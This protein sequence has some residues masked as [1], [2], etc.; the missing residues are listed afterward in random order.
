MNPSLS[1]LLTPGQLSSEESRQL[2]SPVGFS[3]VPLA[4]S[5]LREMANSEELRAALEKALPMLLSALA[6]AASPDGSLVNFERFVQSVP[7]R[8]ELFRYLG[9]NPRAVEILVKLF[10][11]SQFLTEIL[12]RN[13]AYLSELTHHRRLAEFKSRQQIIEEA[14]AAAA[15]PRDVASRLDALRRYQH[16]ELLRIGACDSFGLF[17][18]KSITVQLSLL[19]D[20]MVQTCLQILAKELNVSTDGLAIF[21]FGKLGGEELNYS[22]D[23]DL[24][25][26][27]RDNAASYWTLGQRLIRALT[28]ATGEG[29]MY[30]VDMR[31][32][33]WGS[34]G[35][36]VNTIDAHLAYLRKHGMAWEKQALLKARCIAGD[37]QLG[38]E[39][40][41]RVEP[42]IFGGDPEQYRTTIADMKRKIEAKAGRGGGGATEGA[43][44]DVKSGPGGIRDIE[45][46]VQY[47]Q[48]VHG[49]EQ[50][51]VRSFNTLDALVRLA[52][53]ECL[54]PEEYRRLSNAYVFFRAI[55]HSLQLMHYKQTHRLPD[56]RRELSYLARRLDFGSGDQLL[57]HFE[58][59]S[60]AVRTIFERHL[61]DKEAHRPGRETAD[62]RKAG[63]ALSDHRNQMA[64]S[65]SQ[66]FHEEDIARH[67]TL[68]SRLSPENLIEVEASPL[69]DNTY[70]LTI[71]GYNHLGELSMICG[72]L[73]VHGF[74]IIH[75]DVFTAEQTTIRESEPAARRTFVN[76]FQIAASGARPLE[77]V[78][79]DYKR[80]L[81]ELLRE[82]R[83]G[84]SRE[85]Q[86]RVAKR[87]AGSISRGGE[88]E[89]HV[90]NPRETTS[91]KPR[92][93]DGKESDSRDASGIRPTGVNGGKS[94]Y[95]VSIEIDNEQ[96]DRQTVLHIRS[97][98]T[99][100][101]LFE[102]SNALAMAE[103]EIERVSIRS[104]GDRVFDTLHVTTA[105]G[106]KIT[107]P[108]RLRE[109]RATIVLVKHFSHLLPHVPNPEL[110]LLQFREFLEQL[111]QQENWADELSSL[112]RSDVLDALARLLGVS[113]FLWE[114]F[115]RLQHANLFPVVLDIQSL[116][117]RRDRTVL[118]REL[119][120]KLRAAGESFEQKCLA[121]NAF[122]DRAMFRTD[123][124]HILGHIPE[125]GQF[126]D[127]LTTLAEL[128]VSAGVRLCEHDLRA[129]YGDP[130]LAD[131]TP[132]SLSVLALGKCGGRELGFASDIELM[133]VFA[134]EGRT[135]GKE[136]ITAS[137]YYSRLVECFTQTIQARQAGIFQIDLRLRPYGRAGSLAVS[138]DAF[139]NYFSP[140]GPAW[141][142]ERQALVK[143]R[144]I[145]GDWNFGEEVVRL[146][147]Q[148]LYRGVGFDV[149]AERA[150]R[151]KQV[152]QLVQAGTLNAKLSSG[153]LVDCEYLVQGLQIA[154][155]HRDPALR[156]TRTRDAMRALHEAGV[157]SEQ[158]LQQLHDAYVFLRR[159]IDALRIVRGNARD[160]TVPKRDS[161]EFEFL[162]RRL[163][164][165]GGSLPLWNDLV[166]H[167]ANVQNLDRLLDTKASASA[168]Q[169]EPEA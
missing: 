49:R 30:R 5:R 94:L 6:E 32:R 168:L 108:H 103:I 55:E 115:L 35:A 51:S 159:L 40:L 3:N 147:D 68:L 41:E 31:L 63:E 69:P 42:L 144:P 163:D 95:P 161:E 89:E 128:V 81:Q 100:G 106:E 165:R 102:L 71:A 39:F 164:Y 105:A 91:Q 37:H 111:F 67:A 22:S 57:E 158:E 44:G 66:L 70:R 150:M 56:D 33:P 113:R 166:Q 83:S 160:L 109:L 21:G 145:T 88:G 53:F 139:R 28:E 140:E 14:V 13:P 138:I 151:E 16:W 24:I 143:L 7:S 125:I 38:R 162:A 36:L 156:A 25:F 149:A 10:V 130:L 122:K 99:V 60:S 76:V 78:W 87:V 73:Y 59:H 15:G 27:S 127:E 46:V 136:S 8:L 48:L 93:T 119:G 1:S 80:E 131:G 133:F 154:H 90:N 2:L 157:L 117:E 121:L 129:R 47:L 124:R 84:R 135:T 74:N 19:A 86:G 75:G 112:E 17:D 114:D 72:L 11:G 167:M 20:G 92:A 34:S 123:M 152:R 82:V 132:N 134:G 110:A 12:L 58:R 155:G 97:Q 98:D 153:G 79:S 26:L 141:P 52:D 23:I 104:Q 62:G 101:F 169:S 64:P 54:M 120:A 43:F 77:N 142:Y 18:L 45:F 137:E 9:G 29:F 148:F 146:R 116:A 61:F 85:A 50:P 96:S 126:S 4:L 118:E 65:Y 107:A